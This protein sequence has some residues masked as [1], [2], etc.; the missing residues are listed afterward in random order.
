M[1]ARFV[2]GKVTGAIGTLAFVLA[3]NFFLFRV[4]DDNPVDNLFHGRNLSASQIASLERRFGVG[5]SMVVQFG[6]YVRQTFRGD[7]GISIKSS[8]PVA[9]V[10][11]DAFWPTVWLV[12]TATVLSMV[13]GTL[14]GIE[15]RGS[16]AGRRT[17]RRRRSRW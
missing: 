15:R 14:L 12:G 10:I 11:A 5:D 1:S 3:F 9:D 2:L 16:G 17:R 7:L 13:I 4:V 6:K 8:R